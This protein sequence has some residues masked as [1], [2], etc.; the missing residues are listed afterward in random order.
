ML[1]K[2][3]IEFFGNRQRMIQL[4]CVRVQ[5]QR[6]GG[7]G[8]VIYSASNSDG[9]EFST[10]ILTNH[11]VVSGSIKVIPKWNPMLR[12]EI[13]R[14][15]FETVEA[16]FFTYRYESRAIGGYSVQSDIMTYDPEEDLALL[17]LRS[18]QQAPAVAQLFPRGQE[19]QLR[20]GMKVITVGAGL[21]EDPVQTEGHL[22]QF[23]RDIDRKEYWLNTAP[24]IFGNSGGGMYLKRTLQLVGVPA[25]IGVA[26]L[27]LPDP[28][29]H[30]S[31]AIP[32]TRIYNFL[33][34][35]R[36]RFIYNPEKYSEVSEAEERERMREHA[37]RKLLQEEGGVL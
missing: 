10:Y 28:I 19:N 6:A 27:G 29:T 12:R 7:S 20:I 2:D 1:S 3:D 16:H 4:P 25:R 37:D 9:E 18:P 34:E 26:M 33:E 36:F 22:S 8:T 5:T 21:G 23:G 31:Y 11:H 35:Q 24:S 13:K 17:R 30:L 14:D 15:V 32:I